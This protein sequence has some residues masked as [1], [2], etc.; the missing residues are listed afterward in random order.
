MS[1]A[2]NNNNYPISGSTF[3][4]SLGTITNPNSLTDNNSA[5]ISLK[6][7][8]LI[9]YSSQLTFTPALTSQNLTAFTS[10]TI[11][12]TMNVSQ[13]YSLILLLN[14]YSISYISVIVPS[15]M[16][17]ISMCCIDSS[18]SQ[19]NIN[20]CTISNTLDS[21]VSINLNLNTPQIVN[22]IVFKIVVLDY[23]LSY[24]NANITI[25]SGLP[26]AT[27][28]TTA[29]F[30]VIA[31]PLKSSLT[32]SSWKVS[33][34]ST[35]NLWI[36]PTPQFGYI[37]ISLP[38]YIASQLISTTYSFSIN[39]VVSNVSLMA[40]GAYNFL[41]PINSFTTNITLTMSTVMNPTNSAPYSLNI[42]QGF[43][44]ALTKISATNAY[45][46]AM[47][48]FDLISVT[49][50]VRSVTKVAQPTSL[51]LT[52]TTPSYTEAMIINFPN[53]QQFTSA[54]CSVTAN[55]Q[56]L[57]C[58]VIN[59]T[60][61]VTKNIPGTYDYTI[62]GLYNQKYFILSA[63]YDLI[64]ISLGNPYTRAQTTPTSTTFIAPKLTL[65]SITMNSLT[66][67]SLTLLNPTTLLYNLTV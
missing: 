44:N 60:S 31:T 21:K 10:L 1:V 4:I 42:Y 5:L 49:S 33:T 11:P 29:S 17:N 19:S 39:G 55:S 18:C 13:N 25:N 66:S 8:N 36:A 32:L 30:S 34:P 16:K 48:Q 65:G 46:I 59:S 52:I 24:T 28:T 41:V 20:S 35:Y 47:N 26:S 58:Q 43:D 61:I 57:A 3:N 63:S 51:T 6:N 53:S 14:S 67:S 37:G 64:K 56:T 38:S 45:P 9:A 22:T 12:N 27:F 2:F 54:S 50:V 40:T 62:N 7:S 23:Q 15:F